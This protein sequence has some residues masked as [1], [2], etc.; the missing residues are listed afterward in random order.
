MN[1]FKIWYVTVKM[2]YLGYHCNIIV[3]RKM[4]AKCSL[5]ES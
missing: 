2:F 3:K 1:N 4:W 5:G